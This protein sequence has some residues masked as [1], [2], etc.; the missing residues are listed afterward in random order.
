VGFIR[1][2]Q[3]S[4]L[5][6]AGSPLGDRQLGNDVPTTFE[7][8]IV[9]TPTHVEPRGPGCLRTPNVQQLGI[10]LDTT[11]FAT[12]LAHPL[13]RSPP[14]SKIP[15]RLLERDASF[16]F[17][18]TGDHGAALVTRHE[19]CPED[20]PFETAF[21]AYTKR[22][23]KSWVELARHKQPTYDIHPI[24]V[25]GFD[26][27]KDFSVVVYSNE[28]DTLISDD[29]VAIPMFTSTPPPFLGTWWSGC[30]VQTN[31]GPQQHSPPSR[32]RGTST[33]SSQLAGV[34][35]VTNESNQ[36]VF[37][38]YYTMRWRK[39]LPMFPKVIQ[40]GAGPHDLGPGDNTGGAFPEL[41]VRHNP[42]HTG[43]DGLDL[44]GQWGPATNDTSSGSSIVFRSPKSVWFLLSLF[45][46]VVNLC[47]RNV[48]TGM[49][50]QIT[51]SR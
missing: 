13:N 48:T 5:F 34:G 22:H 50:L 30:P 35:S 14:F 29:T 37:V 46:F 31:E 45:V 32:G 49:P 1:D 23:Y 41:T 51:Y 17:E 18:L 7:Q 47:R 19:T 36:C 42:E 4:L 25:S 2:G 3:F 12:M 21:E 33:P 27:T 43:S 39:W 6:S 44:G 38:W 16:S 15:P 28:D 24:L 8:L 20:T 26:M 40:A 10:S 11:G 9:G